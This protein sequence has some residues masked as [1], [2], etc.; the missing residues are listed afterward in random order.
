MK[1]V[2][3]GEMEPGTI[4]TTADDAPVTPQ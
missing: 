4:M 1:A 2:A 3:K